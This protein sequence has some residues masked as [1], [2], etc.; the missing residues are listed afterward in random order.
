MIE[1]EDPRLRAY[2]ELLE[3]DL[4][5]IRDQAHSGRADICAIESDHIHNIPSLIG[6]SNEHRHL[7]YV[8]KER[9]LYLQRLKTLGD[10]E[11]VER[12]VCQCS[13]PWRVLAA[14]AG[15]SLED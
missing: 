14:I 8:E 4:L 10:A 12:R 3:W 2:L 9:G 7:F 11:Y 15:I 5:M 1:L 13:V 6:D